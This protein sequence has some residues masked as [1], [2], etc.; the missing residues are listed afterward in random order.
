LLN[1]FPFLQ[2]AQALAQNLTLGLVLAALEKAGDEFIENGTQVDIH[3]K[4]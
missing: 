2:Q 4:N 1:L 3:G